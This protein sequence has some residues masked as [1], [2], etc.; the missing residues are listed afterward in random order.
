MSSI[1]VSIMLLGGVV[2]RVL[3]LWSTGCEFDFWPRTS[4]LVLGWSGITGM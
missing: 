3:D 1:R 2:V 4:R